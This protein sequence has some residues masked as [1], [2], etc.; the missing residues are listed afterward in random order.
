MHTMVVI[1]LLMLLAY[2]YYRLLSGHASLAQ[3][4]LL[5]FVAA[6]QFGPLVIAAAYDAPP[7]R[8]QSST[9]RPS[10]APGRQPAHLVPRPSPLP[11]PPAKHG[12][13]HFHEEY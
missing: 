3:I 12:P 7:Q 9:R 10:R 6:A 13:R 1:V 5:S 2:V 8:V 4:G 11:R